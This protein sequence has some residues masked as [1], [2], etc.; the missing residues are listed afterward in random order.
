M[1]IDSD[2]EIFAD[3]KKALTSAVAIDPTVFM[4]GMKYKF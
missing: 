1:D 4:L 3:G 2:A